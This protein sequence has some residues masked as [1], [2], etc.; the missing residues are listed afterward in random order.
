MARQGASGGELP[1]A[2]REH[3]GPEDVVHRSHLTA[4]ALLAALDRQPPQAMH[5]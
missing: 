1:E 3:T 5:L 2:P 4:P